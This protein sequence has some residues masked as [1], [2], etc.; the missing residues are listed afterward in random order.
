LPPPPPLVK[1]LLG[2]LLLRSAVVEDTLGPPGEGFGSME[3]EL[4][5]DPAL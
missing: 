5:R 1:L 2:R 4:T 3:E